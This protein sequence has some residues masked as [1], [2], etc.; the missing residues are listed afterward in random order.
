MVRL[1][2]GVIVLTKWPNLASLAMVGHSP[3]VRRVG[4]DWA[5][6]KR[7]A[8]KLVPNVKQCNLPNI[9]N[10]LS[11]NIYLNIIKPLYSVPLREGRGVGK[12]E[13]GKTNQ[14]H[15]KKKINQ[16]EN[17]EYSAKELVWT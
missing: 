9:T 16:I 13:V 6:L 12:V 10:V 17:I 8:L 1:G 4:R 2:E 15:Y 5:H 14:R 11:K 3:Q 7:D